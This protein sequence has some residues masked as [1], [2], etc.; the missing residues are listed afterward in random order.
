MTGCRVTGYKTPILPLVL[1]NGLP[2]WQ[3]ATDV[4][5]LFAAAPP[6]L[7]AY[8]PQLTYHLIDEARLKLH[9]VDSVRISSKTLNQ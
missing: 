9:P 5:E 3:A 7:A 4:T 2:C 6:E 1:Y 8:R